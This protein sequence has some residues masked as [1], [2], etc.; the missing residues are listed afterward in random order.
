MGLQTMNS[1]EP[2]ETRTAGTIRGRANNNAQV[3][4]MKGNERTR[5]KR[6]T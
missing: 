5:R 6:L 2:K 3:N 4:H 1:Y